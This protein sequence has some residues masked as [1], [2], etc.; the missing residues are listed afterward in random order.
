MD[1]D[2]NLP[3]FSLD[4]IPFFGTILNMEMDYWMI[5]DIIQP[6]ASDGSDKIN[7]P[8]G[9]CHGMLTPFQMLHCSPHTPR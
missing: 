1:A 7:R 2:K 6:Y 4:S 5:F 8:E 3:I 9:R